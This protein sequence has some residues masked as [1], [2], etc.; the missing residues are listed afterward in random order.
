VIPQLGVQDLFLYPPAD[1][2]YRRLYRTGEIR[3]L[4]KLRH[5]GAFAHAMHGA[6]HARWDYTAAMLHYAAAL[7]T[8]GMSADFRIGNTE[9]SSGHAALQCIALMWNAG[10]LPGTFAV[11][12]GVYRFLH[13]RSASRPAAPIRWPKKRLL[14]V[15]SIQNTANHRLREDGYLTVARVL[16]VVKLLAIASGP[17][18]WLFDFVPS[19]ACPF[20]LEYD[21]S[22]SPQWSKLRQAFK[23]VRHLA[24]LTLDTH[25]SGLRWAPR[26]PDLLDDQL[27]KSPSDLALLCDTISEVLSP[28]ERM[29]YDAVYHSPEA[30]REAALLA[31]RVSAHLK[32]QPHPARI[33]EEWLSAGLL[34]ELRLGRRPKPGTHQIAASLRLR[35]HFSTAQESVAKLET[36]LDRKGFAY[37]IVL[38]YR[39]WNSETM[40]E[41]DELLVDIVESRSPS[42]SDVGRLLAWFLAKFDSSTADPIDELELLRKAELAS[43]YRSL[44]RRAVELAFPQ[45]TVRLD[46]WDLSSIRLLK[47]MR[48]IAV[49]AS[50]AKLD[51][52]VVGRLLRKRDR[53]RPA[54]RPSIYVELMGLRELR[55]HLRRRWRAKELRQRWLVVTGSV[56]FRRD[57]RDLIEYDGGLLRISSR[58]GS[59]TWYGLESKSRHGDPAHVLR[60]KLDALKVNA[61]V[62]ALGTRHAFAELPL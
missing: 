25:I 50:G 60:R 53:H 21:S 18:D 35:S 56:R 33:I 13:S 6:R 14:P 51:D 27:K 4:N 39:A 22:D 46:P 58:S 19:F 55:L 20:L 48:N 15:K 5:L 54:V 12:K 28:F 1:Q 24:Y 2:L 9:F 45:V 34:R 11:E 59:L 57:G 37:P 7:K 26:I 43:T 16:A 62:H 47:D 41:P 42:P 29:T 31:S 61:K 44:L 10:H 8:E 52:P 32:A 23:L 17:D 49:W 40:T 38:E 3:R 30:R 36:A